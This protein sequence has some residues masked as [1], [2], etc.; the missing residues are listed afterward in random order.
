MKFKI[1]KIEAHPF[2]TVEPKIERI[3]LLPVDALTSS[4]DCME[5]RQCNSRIFGPAQVGDVVDLPIADLNDE[6]L[7]RVVPTEADL[8]KSELSKMKSELDYLERQLSNT[9]EELEHLKNSDQPARIA[10]IETATE[11]PADFPPSL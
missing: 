5:F 6:V 7:P 8:L 2:A 10:P 4:I 9:N 1:I 3:T 11:D